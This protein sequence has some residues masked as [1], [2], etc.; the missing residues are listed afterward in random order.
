MW[1]SGRGA[2]CW[3]GGGM[4]ARLPSKL[5]LGSVL[6]R[7]KE[8]NMARVCNAPY[9]MHGVPWDTG[10]VYLTCKVMCISP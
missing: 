6:R 1:G 4:C 3:V 10:N 9:Y 5:H 7:P 2:S 8:E